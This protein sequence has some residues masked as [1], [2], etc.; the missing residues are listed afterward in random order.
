MLEHSVKVNMYDRLHMAASA[1]AD[2]S[3]GCEFGIGLDRSNLSRTRLLVIDQRSCSSAQQQ[4]Q[5]LQCQ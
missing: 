4:V 1:M 2:R 3:V 5:V